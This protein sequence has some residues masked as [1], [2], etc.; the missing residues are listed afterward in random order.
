MC[1]RATLRILDVRT[2]IVR[3]Y[4][5]AAAQSI[6]YF[7]NRRDRSETIDFSLPGLLESLGSNSVVR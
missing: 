5:R 3:R 1:N 6:N 7:I 2:E 4:L